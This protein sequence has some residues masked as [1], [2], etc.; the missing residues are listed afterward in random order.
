MTMLF[1]IE[2]YRQPNRHSYEC[3]WDST[4]H[5]PAWDELDD[6]SEISQNIE[7]LEKSNEKVSTAVEVLDKDGE[8]IPLKID[9]T[10]NVREIFLPHLAKCDRCCSGNILVAPGADNW[11]SPVLKTQPVCFFKMQDAVLP[12]NQT[13]ST[14]SH[15]QPLSVLPVNQISSTR[16]HKQLPSV[17][18]VNQTSSTN[19][20][21]DTE[22][23][24][25]VN[26]TSSTNGKTDIETVLPVEQTS[27]TNGKTDIETVL[28]V[29][30]TSSTKR[31]SRGNGTGRIHWRTI[32]KKNG[33]QY[34]QAW[35]D[36]QLPKGKTIHKSTYIPKCL[37]SK[38]QQL[39]AQ[40]APVKK[41]IKVL[42]VTE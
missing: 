11:L 13:S 38:V 32:T 9:Q 10:S 27:S 39:E 29:E 8:E 41:I 5:D 4:V 17:L 34:Q 15:K 7:A 28:P 37:L 36:W 21:A 23:V 35:Y 14:R 24:L 16:S 2:Q 42:G 22:T 31:R 1:D 25:P 18:P 33:K 26:Q 40:K 3:D 12:V 6:F 20:K 30:Q 19:E